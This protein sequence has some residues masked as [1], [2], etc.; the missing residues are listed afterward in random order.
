MS[1]RDS[2]PVLDAL[3]RHCTR[4]EFCCRVRWR[5]GTVVVW[6]NRSTLH[7]AVNDY[8]GERR[9]LYRTAFADR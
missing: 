7:Y 5:P 3:Y 9:L 4:P 2:A 8:D 1:E 6:D